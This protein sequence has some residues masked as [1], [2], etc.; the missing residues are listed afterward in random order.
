MN[1]E[2]PEKEVR[3]NVTLSKAQLGRYIGRDLKQVSPEYNTERYRYTN[4]YNLSTS[5]NLILKYNKIG[6]S[7]A[8][9]QLRTREHSNCQ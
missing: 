6:A 5:H 7:F 9:V 4:L 2:L 8:V 3:G 1:L